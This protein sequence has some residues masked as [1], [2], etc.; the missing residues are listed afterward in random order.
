MPK[1]TVKREGYP[2][3]AYIRKDGVRVKAAQIGPTTFRIKDEG[4]AG[5]TPKEK[6]WFDPQ[7]ETGWK[8]EQPQS[9]RRHKVLRAHRGDE[10]ASARGMQALANV[11]PDRETASKARSDAIFFFRQHRSSVTGRR[12][13]RITPKRPRLRR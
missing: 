10:L 9:I 1:L 7:V 11:S 12:S 5:K 2:R 6:Q 13:V 4:K 3:R 8:K